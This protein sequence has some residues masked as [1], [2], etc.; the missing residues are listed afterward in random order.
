MVVA[1]LTAGFMMER[2]AAQQGG[3]VASAASFY[4]TAQA[5]RGAAVFQSRC[6]GCHNTD[7]TGEKRGSARGGP[8]LTGEQFMSNWEGENLDGLMTRMKTLMPRD[9]PGG[10]ADETYLDLLAFIAKV[11][12]LPGGV[13]PLTA[14]GVADLTIPQ[15]AGSG[16]KAIRNF[17]MVQLV[18]CLAQT[19]NVWTLTHGSEPLVTRDEPATTGELQDARTKALGTEMF[20]LVS[21][22][23]FKPASSQGQRV[24]AKGLIYRAVPGPNRLNLTSLQPLGGNCTN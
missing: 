5:E 9:D 6:S 7:L 22:A 14:E 3:P 2:A 15:K 24:L 8:A 11:N 23:P 19:D 12:A 17:K 18:G 4:S 1:G 13:E 10:L 20:R 21:V 16:T